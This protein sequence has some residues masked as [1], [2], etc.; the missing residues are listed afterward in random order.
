MVR[1]L[2]SPI[3]KVFSTLV[4]IACLLVQSTAQTIESRHLQPGQRLDGTDS[5]RARARCAR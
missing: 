1:A 5:T 3:T 4:L 2:T